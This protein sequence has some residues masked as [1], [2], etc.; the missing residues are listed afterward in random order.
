MLA[1]KTKNMQSAC[2]RRIAWVCTAAALFGG[3]FAFAQSVQSG[4]FVSEAGNGCK[5]WNPHPQPNETATWSGPCVNGYA[6]GKGTVQWSRSDKPQE[7]DE[8]EWREGRQIG[9]GSQDWFAGRYDGDLLDSMPHG[10]G[11]LSLRTDRY[12]GEFHDGKPNGFGTATRADGVFTGS[13]NDGCLINDQ[14]KISIG[15]PASTCR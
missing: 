2:I 14:K 13:W 9:R 8:G 5:V 10:H 7:I 11:V 3:P 6:H 12:E 1:S 4:A 15:V